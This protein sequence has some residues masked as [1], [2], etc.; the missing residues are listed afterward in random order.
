MPLQKNFLLS[1]LRATVE[2]LA[3]VHEI[4]DVIAESVH[5]WLVGELRH[6]SNRSADVRRREHGS[7]R[8]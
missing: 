8:D 2:E 3:A 5:D 6:A 4:G 1:T 7:A